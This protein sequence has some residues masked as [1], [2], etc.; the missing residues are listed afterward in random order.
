MI[1]GD[2]NKI[3]IKVEKDYPEFSQDNLNEDIIEAQWEEINE[4]LMNKDFD[5]VLLGWH[6]STIPDLSF[7]FHSSQIKSGTN[8]INY[9]DE[10]NG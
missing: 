5:M 9:Q 8:F 3:G 10:K 7:A 1:I 6:L 4:K 2:L